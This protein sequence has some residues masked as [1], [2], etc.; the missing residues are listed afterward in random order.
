MSKNKAKKY[1]IQLKVID[2]IIEYL[3]KKRF[4]LLRKIGK[5][6]DEEP[7]RW[8]IIKNNVIAQIV[9]IGGF[10]YLINKL[11]FSYIGIG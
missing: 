2:D 7:R 11:V 6:R 10:L 4:V 1:E 9:D 5:L 8:N 3:T